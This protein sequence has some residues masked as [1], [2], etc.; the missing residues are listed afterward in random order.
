MSIKHYPKGNVIRIRA[1]FKDLA[2]T[3]GDPTAVSFSF[4]NPAGITTT[5]LYNT[6]VELVRETTGVYHVDIDAD[7]VGIWYHKFFSTGTGQAA[8][9]G[10]FVVDVSNF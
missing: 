2:N 3:L 4:K 5:Y 6:D 9:E 10:S 8:A 1:T 7:T